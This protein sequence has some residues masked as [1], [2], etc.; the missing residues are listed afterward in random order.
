VRRFLVLAA[1]VAVAASAAYAAPTSDK[2]KSE[3]ANNANNPAKACKKERADIGVDSFNKK[4]G[5]N[6]N[7]KNAFGKCVSGKSKGKGE[8]KDNEQETEDNDNEQGASQSTSN[9]AKQCKKE[10]ADMD[11][12]AF[13]TKHGTNH[14]KANAFGK[15]MSSKSKKRGKSGDD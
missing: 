7:L 11:A 9:A 4:Y 12:A 1:V 3:N 15:C 8:A 14:N 2:A 10:R 5:T 6:H 13:A